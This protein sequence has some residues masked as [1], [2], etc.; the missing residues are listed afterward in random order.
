MHYF[1]IAIWLPAFVCT[2]SACSVNDSDS[3]NI[4]AVVLWF[5]D[6]LVLVQ[7]CSITRVVKVQ[8]GQVQSKIWRT[9][10]WTLGLVLTMYWILD[11]TVGPVLNSP[12]P[13]PWR[14]E[15][16]TEPWKLKYLWCI[17]F[18]RPGEMWLLWY[19]FFSNCWLSKNALGLRWLQHFVPFNLRRYASK[20]WQN[21][22]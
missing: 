1:A 22:L 16:W 13:V 14:S 8:F 10:N 11:Q 17:S 19:T 12:A 2:I 6:I 15:P 3:L 20:G 9:K 7:L 5:G 4:F 21:L 18:N